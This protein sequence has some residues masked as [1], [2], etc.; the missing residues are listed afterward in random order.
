MRVIEAKFS[1]TE[2][3]MNERLAIVERRLSE[4]EKKLMRNPPAA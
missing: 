1:N 3:A 4:I 2:I